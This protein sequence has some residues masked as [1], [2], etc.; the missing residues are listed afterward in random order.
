MARDLVG[1]AG[2]EEIEAIVL[3]TEFHIQAILELARPGGPG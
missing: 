3:P 1:F 2:D